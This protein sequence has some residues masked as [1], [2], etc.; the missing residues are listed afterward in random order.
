MA[1]CKWCGESFTPST[2][3]DHC[4]EQC[5]DQWLKNRE[6]YWTPERRE[7]LQDQLETW[8]AQIEEE[9]KNKPA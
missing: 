3:P 7:K 6:A 1:A 2:W 5:L 8:L 9:L 4:S